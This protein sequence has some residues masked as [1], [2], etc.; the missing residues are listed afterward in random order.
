MSVPLTALY[1]PGDR[2]DRWEKAIATGADVVIIDLEDAVAPSRKDG[3][4]AE[5]AAL[6]H[7]SDTMF[8]VRVNAR[9]TGWYDADLEA[10]AALPA[11]IGVR[12]PKVQSPDDVEALAEQI[13]GR[14]IHALIESALG[15]ERAFEI[16]TAGVR[17]IGLGEADLR[18]QLGLVRGPD[19]EPGLLWARSRVVNAAAAAG[20]AAPMMSVYADI[21]DLDG[22]AVSC[23]AGRAL[24]FVGR[25][26]IHPA[27]L[28]TI[29]AA[30]TPTP[31]EVARAR[32]V[33]TRV[34]T[35]AAG[36]VGT[37]VLDDGTFLDVAMVDSARRT[38]ALA[39][40]R[41]G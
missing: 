2:P 31:D 20:I 35:A 10:V 30:F 3:A 1:V 16:A 38:I 17:S 33:I 12:V 23:A 27:Q 40:R 26:A 13:G 29:E 4:R 39:D 9:G 15:V 32:E 22:L 6:P 36:G 24:G 18:S 21:A 14:A 25:A 11:D 41:R 37:V 34:A 19:G 5:L 28:A 7:V 8:Q